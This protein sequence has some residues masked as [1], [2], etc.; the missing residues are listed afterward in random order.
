M[1]QQGQSFRNI[2]NVLTTVSVNESSINLVNTRLN[3]VVGSGAA[4]KN[5]S[6]Q[7]NTIFGTQALLV[8]AAGNRLVAVGCLAARQL[9]TGNGAVFMGDR[10]APC[11]IDGSDSIFI[12]LASGSNALVAQSCVLLGPN[13]SVS[14]PL[15]PL[16]DQVA[17]GSR[18]VVGGTGGTVVGA[19]SV[20][21]GDACVCVGYCNIHHAQGGI[22]VGACCSNTCAGSIIIGNGLGFDAAVGSDNLTIVAGLGTGRL[23]IQNVLTGQPNLAT[24]VYDLQLA[25]PS[26]SISL[27]APTGVVASGSFSAQTLTTPSIT[28]SPTSSQVAGGTSWNISLASPTPHSGTDLLLASSNGTQ[29]TFCDDFVPGILNFTA[30]HRCA[31]AHASSEDVLM[32]GSVVVATGAYLGL[33]GSDAPSID[34]SVPVVA[35][36]RAARDPRVFGVVSCHECADPMQRRIFRVGSLGFSLPKNPGELLTRAVINAGGEG[37]ILVCNANG[38]ITNGDLLVSSDRV[39]LAMRQGD[40]LVRACTVAKATCDCSFDSEHMLL[41]CG[42]MIGCAYMC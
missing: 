21:S 32:P 22:T 9:L 23:N 24:Y 27:V 19:R 42:V 5:T 16:T 41:G 3:S 12:G 15:Q 1:S 30:Q 6:G 38:P 26:G 2:A 34:E 8:N 28:V 39:G 13:I 36:S 20:A 18:S 25:T 40:D 17:V 37:G 35:P 4:T 14:D 29:V 11:L 10:V 33:D 31:L 7:E